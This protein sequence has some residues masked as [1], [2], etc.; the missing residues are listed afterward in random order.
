M[1]FKEAKA[2]CPNGGSIYRES[3][4]VPALFEKQ[5]FT[6]IAA[7]PQGAKNAEDWKVS[8]NG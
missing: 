5:D 3:A 8:A 7:M 1:T 2:S 6:G 4:P